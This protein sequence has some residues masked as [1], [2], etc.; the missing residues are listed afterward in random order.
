MTL[1]CKTTAALGFLILTMLAPVSANALDCEP[2]VPELAVFAQHIVNRGQARN[3]YQLAAKDRAIATQSCG[4]PYAD[5]SFGAFIKTRLGKLT[6]ELTEP[7]I[8][9]LRQWSDTD[10]VSILRA[11]RVFFTASCEVDD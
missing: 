11:Y 2:E 4:C 5:W 8:R 3:A 6:A 9:E 7:D 10:G 1:G